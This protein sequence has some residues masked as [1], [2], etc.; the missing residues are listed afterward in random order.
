M[1]LGDYIKERFDKAVWGLGYARQ[2]GPSTLN[3]MYLS[4]KTGFEL[5]WNNKRLSNSPVMSAEREFV[6]DASNLLAMKTFS[7]Q[8]G[9]AAGLPKD[10]LKETLTK[11]FLTE[12][13]V[14][15]GLRGAAFGVVAGL[16][17]HVI[18]K[19]FN[20]DEYNERGVI[21][22]MSLVGA[23]AAIGAVGGVATS[24]VNNILK[25]TKSSLT[26]EL[27]QNVFKAGAEGNL[28]AKLMSFGGK[29][30]GGIGLGLAA[31]GTTAYI[32]TG[33]LKSIISTNLTRPSNN[34]Q[35]GNSIASKALYHLI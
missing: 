23:S 22:G 6:K 1:G 33:V 9:Y 34:H 16:G 29:R 10:A 20:P 14:H 31:L 35:E 13:A 4:S 21:D 5:G 12:S 17:T 32:G 19:W 30:L 27:T 28:G 25:N 26:T 3:S 15:G 18:N 8:V 11:K 2:V 24:A 7:G